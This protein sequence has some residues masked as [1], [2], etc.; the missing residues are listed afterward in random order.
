MEAYAKARIQEA[1]YGFEL[2]E[3][4]LEAGLVRNAAGKAFQ[5]W[6]AAL[7]AAAALRREL[8]LGEFRG[9][10]R[11]RDGKLVDRADLVIALMPTSLMERVARVL[12]RE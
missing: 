1:L 8:L 4:F 5:G 12:S 2:A 9:A 11:T 6:K 10:A 7:A 3:K